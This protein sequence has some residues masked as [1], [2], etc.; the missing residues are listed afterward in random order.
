MSRSSEPAARPADDAFRCAHCAQLVT[1]P[2]GGTEQRNHCPHC[3]WSLHVDFQNGDRRSACRSPMEPI[4][5]WAKQSGEWAVIHRC[6][7]CGAIRANRIAGDDNEAVLLSL[8]VRPL[9]NPAFSLER[10]KPSS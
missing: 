10:L 7:E 4:A 9:A 1:P 2:E 8:A 5:I 6:K 3:L